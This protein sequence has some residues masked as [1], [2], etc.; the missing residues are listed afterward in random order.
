MTHRLRLNR[1]SCGSAKGTQTWTPRGKRIA[2]GITPTTSYDSPFSSSVRPTKP[3]SPPESCCQS[4]WL[5]TAT[6]CVPSSDCSGR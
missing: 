5:T 6:R 4:P 2:G 3:G 1:S